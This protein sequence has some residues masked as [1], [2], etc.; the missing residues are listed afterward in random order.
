MG[1]EAFGADR[2][3]FLIPSAK[4]LITIPETNDRLVLHRF[5]LDAA[6]DKSGVDYLFVMSEPP[7]GARKAL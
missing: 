6:L 7:S 5:D 4:V 2:R 1:R 3:I